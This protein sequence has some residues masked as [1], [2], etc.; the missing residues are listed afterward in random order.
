[1]FLN[2][3]EV[4]L[5]ERGIDLPTNF[6]IEYKGNFLM[7]TVI[8]AAYNAANF[9]AYAIESILN[10][11]FA[12]WELIVIDDGSTDNTIEI[13]K[14]YIQLDQ[15][16]RL[17]QSQHIGVCQAR[18]IGIQSAKYSWIAIMDADDIAL[19]QRLEKQINAAIANPDVVAWGSYVQHISPT[20]NILSLQKYLYILGR[21]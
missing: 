5:R 18:N 14:N 7:I 21:I 20:G 3:Q 15:R 9:I 12:N 6:L 19:P 11:S 4:D 2:L 16:V 8:M 17:I 10:Q 1:M 13:I